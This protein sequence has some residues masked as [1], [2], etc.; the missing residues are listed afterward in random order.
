MKL[1]NP[2]SQCVLGLAS[3]GFEIVHHV[4]SRFAAYVYVIALFAPT[5]SEKETNG[6]QRDVRGNV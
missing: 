4:T 2:Q 3:R 5:A 6:R 1:D